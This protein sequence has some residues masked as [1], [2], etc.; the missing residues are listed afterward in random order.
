MVNERNRNKLSLTLDLQDPR[1]KKIFL[2]LV[3]KSDIVSQ[4]F[5]RRVMPNL[6]LDYEALRAANPGIILISLMSQGLD[7]PERDFVS[8][9]PNLEQ[10]G[11]ISFF[12]GYPDEAGSSIGFALP[13]PLGGA[14]AALAAVAALRYRSLTGEGLHVDLSQRE[15]ASLVIGRELLE[16]EL[17]GKTPPRLGNHELG[18]SPADCYP[19]SGVDE[20]IAIS[21]QS[22]TEWAALSRIIG[23][24]ELVQDS[25]FATLIARRRN[26]K[27]LDQILADWTRTRKKEEAMAELQSV[28]VPAGAVFNPRELF[29]N[30]HLRQRQF[31][32]AVDDSSAGRQ[33]YYGRAFHLSG[34][35][36]KT[37]LPSPRLGEHNR[38][39]LTELLQ[40]TG[41]EIDAL[42]RDGVIGTTPSGRTN[43]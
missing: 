26:K 36:L 23:R 6:G 35:E 15:A 33:E 7:G 12:S 11:G 22:D 41:D 1:G 9:G 24:P 2:E 39:I 5:S 18:A 4:N 37:R 28:G 31:W 43:Q 10:L 21:V 40:M 14:T 30:S 17:T 20:W 34:T 32:E 27:E 16:Y 19:T 3:T 13:D 38:I 25:R 42:E 29:I 8:F